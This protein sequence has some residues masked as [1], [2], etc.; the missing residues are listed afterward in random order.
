MSMTSTLNSWWTIWKIP[1]MITSTTGTVHSSKSVQNNIMNSREGEYQ[2]SIMRTKASGNWGTLTWSVPA[3]QR[4]NNVPLVRIASNVITLRNYH[5][6]LRDLSPDSVIQIHAKEKNCV[7]KHMKAKT[8]DCK[9]HISK[10]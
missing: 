8:A 1:V 7:H 10:I 4:K 2:S 9:L 3:S 5:N 6:I